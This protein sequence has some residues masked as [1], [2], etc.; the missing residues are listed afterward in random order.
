VFDVRDRSGDTSARVVCADCAGM[1][2]GAI[3]VNRPE[4]LRAFA[5][6]PEIKL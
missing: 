6:L 2:L 4:V 5:D 1:L 3:K